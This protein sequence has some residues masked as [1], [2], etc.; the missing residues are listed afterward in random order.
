[1]RIFGLRVVRDAQWQAAQAELGALRKRDHDM[2]A[3][4]QRELPKLLAIAGARPDRLER[5]TWNLRVHVATGLLDRVA[6]GSREWVRIVAEHVG[7]AVAEKL[8]ED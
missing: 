5:S 6:R 2:A 8:G 4:L 7:R 1:M 3:V